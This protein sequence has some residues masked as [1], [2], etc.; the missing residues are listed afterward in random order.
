MQSRE[1]LGLVN[2]EPQLCLSLGPFKQAVPSDTEGSRCVRPETSSG[3]FNSQGQICLLSIYGK[4][5]C[6][7][8]PP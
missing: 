4:E 3:V 8:E 7:E 5:E 1:I 6:L 2:V